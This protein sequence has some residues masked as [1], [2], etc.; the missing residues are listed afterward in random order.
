MGT[1]LSDDT[2]PRLDRAQDLLGGRDAWDVDSVKGIF[3]DHHR[4]PSSICRHA[5]LDDPEHTHMETVGSFIFD[6]EQ[7][8]AHVTRGQPC[9][10]G[11]STVAL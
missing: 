1:A 9:Q 3:V 10:N 2:V 11:Y 7:G 5:K 8:I 4:G 6:L